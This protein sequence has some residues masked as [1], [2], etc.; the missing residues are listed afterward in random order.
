MKYLHGNK[1]ISHAFFEPWKK[2]VKWILQIRNP[3]HHLKSVGLAH[4]IFMAPLKL[5]TLSSNF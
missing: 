2:A 5:Q 1:K 3:K 4:L